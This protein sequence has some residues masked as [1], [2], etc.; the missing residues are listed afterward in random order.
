M[1]TARSLGREAAGAIQE[2]RLGVQEGASAVRE[3]AFAGQEG[4]FAGQEGASA[5]GASAYSGEVRTYDEASGALAE[6]LRGPDFQVAEPG[7]FDRA[8]MAVR[9]TLGELLREIVL[10]AADGPGAVAAWALGGAAAVVL[11]VALGRV[12]L[13][14]FGRRRQGRGRSAPGPESVRTTA[15]W[16]RV[17]AER[18]EQGD[19]R[20]AATALYQAVLLALDGDGVVAFHPSKTPGEY[21]TEA[22]AKPAGEDAERFLGA[23]QRLSFGRRVPADEAYRRLE[24]LARGLAGL[25]QASSAAPVGRAR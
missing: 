23:F 24:R 3:G 25:G 9:E 8:M 14:L 2:R 12:L 6:I 5:E 20:G 10:R 21:A 22:G 13:R 4:G 15:G 19:Y 11:A 16:W 17:A 18:A 7:W 1:R